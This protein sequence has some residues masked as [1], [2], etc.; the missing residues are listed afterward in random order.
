MEIFEKIAEKFGT[1]TYVYFADTIREKARRVLEVF[2][3]LEVLPTFA[4]KANGN[5]VLDEFAA[6][7]THS[8]L[9]LLGF[10][11]GRATEAK[12]MLDCE[13]RLFRIAG[14]EVSQFGH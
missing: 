10:D 7:G 14:I 2:E 5:P 4:V 8:L 12:Q 1:P 3:N 11:H 13:K 6:V 9:H